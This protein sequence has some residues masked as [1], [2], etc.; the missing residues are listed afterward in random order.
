MQESSIASDPRCWVLCGHQYGENKMD[1]H[2]T[3]DQAEQ[4]AGLLL[5][6]VAAA[7]GPHECGPYGCGDGDLCEAHDV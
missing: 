4:L 3:I 1:P 6:F 2:L 5:D 7:R